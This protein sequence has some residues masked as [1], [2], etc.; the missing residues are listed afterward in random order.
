M[1]AFA[2]KIRSYAPHTILIISGNAYGYDV[3]GVGQQYPFH[4]TNALFA[5][6]VFDHPTVQQPFDWARAFGDVAAFKASA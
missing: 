2:T 1:D 3:S 6:H 4:V 5:T